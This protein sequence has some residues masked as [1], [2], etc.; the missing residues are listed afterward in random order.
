LL[1]FFEFNSITDSS[2]ISALYKFE[3]EKLIFT[4]SHFHH[5]VAR[6]YQEKFSVKFFLISLFSFVIIL[7][8]FGKFSIF[9]IFSQ[10]QISLII[11]ELIL[12]STTI[13]FLLSEISC[14]L[15]LEIDVIGLVSV[16]LQETKTK[17]KSSKIKYFFIVKKFK[18]LKL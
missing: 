8:S 14:L 18:K 15:F 9:S 16:L 10:L 17:L 4:F 11:Q 12:F 13:L 3:Y 1:S 6:I 5:V 2:F 7:L